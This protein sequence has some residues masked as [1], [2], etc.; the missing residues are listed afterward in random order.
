MGAA[1]E[2]LE[3]F[4]DILLFRDLTPAQLTKLSRIC[5]KVRTAPGDLVFNAGSA[6]DA[7]YVLRSGRVAVV[8]PGEAGEPEET[9]A[10][11]GAG[12]V[13]GEMAL[14]GRETRSATIRALEDCRLFRLKRDYFTQLLEEDHDLA[15]KLYRRINAILTDRLRETTDRLAIANRIIRAASRKT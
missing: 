3:I 15:L 6:G 10:E 2:N 9:V 8:K 1:V 7:L 4:K 13:F 5:Q 14:F 12:D 11:L